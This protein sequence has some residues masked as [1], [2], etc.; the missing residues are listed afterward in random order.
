M[1]N[2]HC[3][4][5]GHGYKGTCC[6]TS[7]CSP[8]NSYP[9]AAS[10]RCEDSL[11]RTCCGSYGQNEEKNHVI[12]K[13]WWFAHCWWKCCDSWKKSI[14]LFGSIHETWWNPTF[15]DP[16]WSHVW[17]PHLRLAAVPASC[18]LPDWDP[19]T[20]KPGLS[21]SHFWPAKRR[22]KPANTRKIVYGWESMSIYLQ[23]FACM[24]FLTDCII[25]NTNK[26]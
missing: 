2:L 1:I 4:R 16:F 25:L 5:H 21:T 19:F 11:W 13:C 3:N 17:L 8:W 26:H 15:S 12:T 14:S 10:F 24:I 18:G 6:P 22:V 20:Y 23:L 7:T 9:S